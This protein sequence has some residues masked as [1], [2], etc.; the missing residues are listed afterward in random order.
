VTHARNR[1]DQCRH[2]QA[3]LRKA[4]HQTQH[5]Q[6]AGQ[7]GEGGEFAGSRDEADDDDREIKNVPAILEVASRLRY[8]R[9]E[10]AERFDDENQQKQLIEE[11]KKRAES[12]R[13]R[14]GRVETDDDGVGD[15]DEGDTVLE[16]AAGDPAFECCLN[17]DYSRS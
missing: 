15:D 16:P 7:P 8:Q 6:Q 3:Q 13:Q 1:T 10:F 5:P 2:D 17:D 4:G 14:I 9:A 11:G 12:H